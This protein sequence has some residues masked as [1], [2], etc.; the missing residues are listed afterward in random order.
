MRPRSLMQGGS[1]KRKVTGVG[2]ERTFR[3]PRRRRSEARG[4]LQMSSSEL[5]M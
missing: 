5:E 2:E 1:A 3:D 4:E